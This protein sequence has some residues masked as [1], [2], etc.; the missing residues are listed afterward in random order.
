M[1]GQVVV[2]KVEKKNNKLVQTV[3]WSIQSVYNGYNTQLREW[4]VS[5]WEMGRWYS[6]CHTVE[7]ERS[8]NNKNVIIWYT[9]LFM[10]C[11]YS[12]KMSLVI[13]NVYT[14]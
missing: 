10:I 9:D 4:G 5:I 1:V 14:M 11:D 3:W 12:L 13:M 6:V 8:S 7:S 2:V